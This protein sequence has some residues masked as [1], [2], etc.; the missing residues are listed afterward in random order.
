MDTENCNFSSTHVYLITVYDVEE[1]PHLHIT[2]Y[3]FSLPDVNIKIQPI[4]Q[5]ETEN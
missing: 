4:K 3:D 5:F 2:K 1:M